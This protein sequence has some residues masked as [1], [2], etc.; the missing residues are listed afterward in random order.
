MFIP[1]YRCV[2]HLLVTYVNNRQKHITNVNI[3]LCN[4]DSA[5]RLYKSN[6][7]LSSKLRWLKLTKL[8]QLIHPTY[9]FFFWANLVQDDRYSL[10]FGGY[11]CHILYT[12]TSVDSHCCEY[13]PGGDKSE[14]TETTMWS[15]TW[16]LFVYSLF[17][18]TPFES[19][20]AIIK[21]FTLSVFQMLMLSVIEIFI[22][23]VNEMFMWS[24]VEMIMLS[25]IKCS[26][27]QSLG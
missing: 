23:S 5:H 26:C 7:H 18:L 22:L 19:R 10:P 16:W 13:S 20:C 12:A 27:R 9:D 4:I 21:M 1:S 3:F 14:N 6:L 8:T 17:L 24:V 2:I 11:C 25:V 15:K